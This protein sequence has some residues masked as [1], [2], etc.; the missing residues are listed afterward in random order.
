MYEGIKRGREYGIISDGNSGSG[1]ATLPCGA[2]VAMVYPGEHVV[3]STAWVSRA[4]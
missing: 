3:F 4:L 2:S 1:D